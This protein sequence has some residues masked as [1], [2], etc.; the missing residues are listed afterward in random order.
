MP[1]V[2]NGQRVGIG[3]S[4]CWH[5]SQAGSF[6]RGDPPGFFRLEPGLA[7]GRLADLFMSGQALRFVSRLA[8]R[9]QLALTLRLR[10]RLRPALQFIGLAIP[11]VGVLPGL[12]LGRLPGALRGLGAGALRR[13]LASFQ[14]CLIGGL[15]LG[16]QFHFEVLGI[17]GLQPQLPLALLQ[18]DF[19][20]LAQRITVRDGF[21]QI[22]PVL[23]QFALV[24]PQRLVGG[25]LDGF[26]FFRRQAQQVAQFVQC[27]ALERRDVAVGQHLFDLG[28]VPRCCYLLVVP[29]LLA[30]VQQALGEL[31]NSGGHIQKG[32][33]LVGPSRDRLALLGHRLKVFEFQP[34]PV[35][36]FQ[37]HRHD[38]RLAVLAPLH[39]LLELDPGAIVRRDEVRA[40]QQQDDVG[41]LEVA[42]DLIRPVLTW[43]DLVVGPLVD[44]P[45]PFQRCQVLFELQFQILIRV[46]VGNEERNRLAVFH[47]CVPFLDN[48][49]AG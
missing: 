4:P 46:G 41:G 38:D 49:R 32:Q 27:L 18:V 25:I 45:V 44:E 14:L 12:A 5:F 47:C 21:D 16:Q 20:A 42:V 19:G 1:L 7:L 33:I 28:L 13:G 39:G 43:F 22:D 15:G 35:A 6:G 17:F 11:Q 26:G 23:A 36:G 9:R 31:T 30:L 37:D 34:H 48:A 40:D 10:L 29:L 8:L 2:G 24:L 3:R